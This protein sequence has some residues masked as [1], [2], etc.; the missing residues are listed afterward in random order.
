MKDR[1]LPS[2]PLVVGLLFAALLLPLSSHR[3]LAQGDPTLPD[4]TERVRKNTLRINLFR[5]LV[6]GGDNYVFGYERV[7]SPTQSVSLNVGYIT[8]P[9]VVIRTPTTTITRSNA[10][11]GLSLGLDYRFYL[12]SKN[13]NP[14]PDGVYLGPYIIH[15]DTRSDN[16]IT[17]R[18][19]DL[20]VDTKLRVNGFGVEMGYQFVI[21][22]RFTVD[23]I[24]VAPGFT[25]YRFDFI[26]RTE[27]D[28]EE[29]N[30]LLEAI[31]E[32][33]DAQLPVIDI[34]DIE[35]FRRTGRASTW[36]LGARLAFQI[37]FHF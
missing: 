21:K 30:D 14:A 31:A 28:E 35:E 3:L 20:D 25:S 11:A 34:I 26:V 29:L 2:S 9:L 23:L 37:G 19:L 4:E 1:W 8:F 27:I 33:F 6:F 10:R 12:K 7:L 15:V 13:R 22:K 16:N 18:A 24:L 17:W 5:K 36:N 32:R